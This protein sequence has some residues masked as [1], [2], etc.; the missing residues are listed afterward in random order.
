MAEGRYL[1]NLENKDPDSF[2]YSAIF[3]DDPSS[4]PV[5]GANQQT[6]AQNDL[7]I[8]RQ[9]NAFQNNSFQPG[10]EN[11]GKGDLP[12]GIID[13]TPVSSQ[14]KSQETTDAEPEE[15]PENNFDTEE[16]SQSAAPASTIMAFK[17]RKKIQPLIKKRV[18]ALGEIKK[19]DKKIKKLLPPSMIKKAFLYAFRGIVDLFTA[20]ALEP[21]F[22]GVQIYTTVK[23]AEHKSQIARLKRKNKNLQ[24]EVKQIEKQINNLNKFSRRKEEFS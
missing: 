16:P 9:R 8:E 6:S 18:A 2:D 10:L 22:S 23:N 13:D 20:G 19:N 5:L 3:H 21:V 24:G 4:P 11:L 7:N 14:K 15:Q 17:N 1:S 12:S